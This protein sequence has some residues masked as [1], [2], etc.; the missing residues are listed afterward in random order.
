MRSELIEEIEAG[1]ELILPEGAVAELRILNTRKGTL[2]GYFDD[3]H[4]MAVAAAQWSGK[5]PGVYFTLNPVDPELLARSFNRLTEFARHTTADRDILWRSWLPLDFD[6]VRRAGMSSTEAE[7]QLALDRAADCAAYIAQSLHWGE[8]LRADSGNGAHLLYRLSWPNNDAA[9]DAVRR[10]L[11]GVALTFSDE[12]VQVD[13]ST[14]NAARIWK[15]YGTLACKGDDVPER[16]HRKARLLTTFPPHCPLI[17]PQE[18]DEE[19]DWERDSEAA[20]DWEDGS[21]RER[22]AGDEEGS[23]NDGT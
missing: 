9:R 19:P 22:E 18:A 7:H 6:P 8:P 14:F 15:V 5:A 2:S 11:E 21:F 13:T 20:W 16:P 23:W 10:V 1:L 17:T 4:R 3:R 12:R